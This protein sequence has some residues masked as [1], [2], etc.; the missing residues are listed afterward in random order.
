MFLRSLHCYLVYI[1]SK[2]C[3]QCRCRLARGVR[4]HLEFSAYGDKIII[5][6]LAP[7]ADSTGVFDI[8]HGQPAPV[9]FSADD[10]SRTRVTS[11]GS[12][13]NTVIRRPQLSLMQL[14]LTCYFLLV[15]MGI[16]LNFQC[17]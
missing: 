16:N 5:F 6:R 3:K 12:S 4:K 15:N 11:L 2:T 17:I 13:G 8:P 14:T 1:L 7:G 10:G 9:L